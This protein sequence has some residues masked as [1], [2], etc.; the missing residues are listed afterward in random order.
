MSKKQNTGEVATTLSSSFPLFASEKGGRIMSTLKEMG[1]QKFDL[2]KVAA[3]AGGALAFE[4]EGLDGLEYEKE[5]TVV[6]GLMV[7]GQRAWYRDSFEDT[8]G[9]APDCASTNGSTGFG[10]RDAEGGEDSPKTEMEC[11]L[12]PYNQWESSRSGGSGR[13]CSEK[14]LLYAF[15][16]DSLIPVVLQVSATSLKPL[17]RYALKLL[18]FGLELHDVVTGIT[19]EKKAGRVEHSVM[20]FRRV[21]S[22][23]PEHQVTMGAVS[24][25]LAN[26]FAG[27]Q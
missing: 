8:G 25:D 22:L 19:L 6:V 5:L 7:G 24:N 10:N 12:C 16:K 9:A 11:K 23:S 20:A 26:A 27:A 17:K 13:D 15:T 4:V 3:P 2:D 21:E 1:V 18:G 14:A